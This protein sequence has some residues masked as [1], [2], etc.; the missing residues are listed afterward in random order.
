MVKKVVKSADEYREEILSQCRNAGLKG[1]KRPAGKSAVVQEAIQSLVNSGEV[2]ER[3][4]GAK[5]MLFF[6]AALPTLDDLVMRLRE[7]ATL[8]GREGMKSKDLATYRLACPEDLERALRQLEEEG[9]LV[10]VGGKKS[11]TYYRPEF[12]PKPKPTPREI[13]AQELTARITSGVAW[14]DSVLA[15]SGKSKLALERRALLDEWVRQGK[16]IRFEIVVGKGKVAVAYRLPER[17]TVRQEN[18]EEVAAVP[19]WSIMERTAR[20]MARRSVDG[21]VSFEELADALQTTPLVVKTAVSQQ[22]ARE[23]P[24]RLV[25]GEARDV[26]HPATA[27]LEFRGETFYRFEFID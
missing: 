23:G 11:V 15:G 14:V 17:G 25:R 1:I 9:E 22:M 12:A 8:Y 24:V 16:L 4:C 27:G 5:R 20:E 13:A 7:Q 18:V 6:S 10:A 19:E 3:V 2:V 21:T 26:R